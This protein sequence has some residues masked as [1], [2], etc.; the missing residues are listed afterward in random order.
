MKPEQVVE[1]ETSSIVMF[2][3]YLTHNYIIS[4]LIVIVVIVITI[5]IVTTRC[6]ACRRRRRSCPSISPI[7]DVFKQSCSAL[8]SQAA[9]PLRMLVLCFFHPK[10][11]SVSLE[12]YSL[13][14]HVT[15]AYFLACLDFAHQYVDKH[16]LTVLL[17]IVCLTPVSLLNV[18][19]C[20]CKQ[21]TYMCVHW[22]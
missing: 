4:C 8:P 2:T 22:L 11:L 14:R 18:N 9:G 20:T 7:I 21:R 15:N 19:I 12:V 5:I 17:S 16:K 3:F 1:R 6:R 10:Y 13:F